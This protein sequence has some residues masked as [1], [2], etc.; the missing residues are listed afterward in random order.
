MAEETL[1]YGKTMALALGLLVGTVMLT[2]TA[3]ADNADDYVRAQM[4]QRHIP[5]LSV[6]VVQGGKVVK[7]RGYGSASLAPDR[8]V[9]P[10]TVFNLASLTKQFTAAAILRLAQDG[11]LGVDD[12]AAHFV[13]DWPAAWKGITVR[14][15]LN[16]TTGIPNFLE[17]I[18]PDDYGK[19]YSTRDFLEAAASKPLLFAPGAQY[20]YSNTNYH[21][22]ALVVEKAG[23]RPYG[24]YLHDTFFGPLGMT[25]TRLDGSGPPGPDRARGYGWDGSRYVPDTL[26]LDPSLDF[27]DRGVLSTAPDLVKWDAALDGD[28]VLSSASK[29]VLWTPPAL[30]GGAQ[31]SYAAGWIAQTVGG[32][33]LLWHN[34]VL[35]FSFSAALLRFPD[36]RLSVVLLANSLKPADLL[37]L[38]AYS[39]TLGL[40]KLYLPDLAKADAGIPDSN[41]Q[42]AALVRTVSAQI[43]AGKLDPGLFA[44]ALRAALTPQAVAPARALLAPLGPLTSLAL[45][46]R[47]AGG[48]SLYR[49][50]YG[51]IAVRWLI[52]VDAAHK[53]TALR[54][55]AE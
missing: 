9:T 44:P 25:H 31:T 24:A 20:A 4:A 16:Q 10:E 41:P 8:P 6:A 23:G 19:F 3:R 43:A 22:L 52:A 26:R 7:M 40:A 47:D 45:L 12:E 15:L 35:P 38:P 37:S 21:L 17:T 32:H 36:D 33:R 18:P 39:L 34:G 14:Q 48:T 2:G 1:M 27:G 28:G 46:A 50:L 53:I 5:G 42:T 55:M 11:K 29:A 49:A 13:A 51:P 54:P 30:P